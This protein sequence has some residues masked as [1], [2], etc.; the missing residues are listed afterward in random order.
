[1]LDIK[2][3]EF[4]SSEMMKCTDPMSLITKSDTKDK[5]IA[6]NTLLLKGNYEAACCFL[7]LK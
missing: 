1:M 6:R 5:C 3:N 7:V 2:E 4:H